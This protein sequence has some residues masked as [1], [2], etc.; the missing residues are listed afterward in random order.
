MEW[1]PA[2]KAS[3]VAVQQD[4][5]GLE[6]CLRGRTGSQLIGMYSQNRALLPAIAPS[7]INCRPLFH[8]L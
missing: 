6:S 4:E 5:G 7:L 3:G 8:G 2:Q 1:V